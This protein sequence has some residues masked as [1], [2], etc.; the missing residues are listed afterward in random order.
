MTEPQHLPAQLDVEAGD[1][2]ED[3][4]AVVV[5]VGEPELALTTDGIDGP[6]R[7]NVSAPPIVGRGV[8]ARAMQHAFAMDRDVA[9]L[10]EYRDC[11]LAGKQIGNEGMALG[12]IF[13]QRPMG[14][15]RLVIA[16]R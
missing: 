7:N 2:A 11:G 9:A 16:P 6:Q 1:L 14:A 5:G 4:V 3:R 15:N 12:A 13:V 8:S 10:D